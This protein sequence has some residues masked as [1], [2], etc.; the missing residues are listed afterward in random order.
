M[1]HYGFIQDML[2]V[3]VLILLVMARVNTPL[4]VSQIYELSFQDDK[5]TYFDVCEAVPQMVET[6][7]LA[8]VYP[9]HFSITESG[10]EI[11]EVMESSIAYPVAERAK[12]AAAEYNQDVRRDEVINTAVTELPSGEALVHLELLDEGSKLMT[13]E[14]LSPTLRQGWKLEKTYR[15]RAETI[16]R[17]IMN[18]FGDGTSAPEEA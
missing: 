11:G 16:Y 17:C 4:T 15:K 7:Q 1:E 14:L 13:L 10:R 12:A 2:D 6:G 8:E 3:K 9:E 18:A 5:L